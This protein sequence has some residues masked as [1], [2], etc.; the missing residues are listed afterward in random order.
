MME[1]TNFGHGADGFARRR[2]DGARLG[3]VFVERLRLSPPA[4]IQA[5]NVVLSHPSRR[6]CFIAACARPPGA[7]GSA[8]HVNSPHA[9]GQHPGR[10]TSD[11]RQAKEPRQ[12][13]RYGPAGTRTEPATELA[14]P[15]SAERLDKA[16]RP[17]ASA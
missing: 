13:A 5:G 1:T 14:Q 15:E 2:L 16:G 12:P 8:L 4:V 3:R 11:E 9:E 7:D 10:Q 17:F 6:P